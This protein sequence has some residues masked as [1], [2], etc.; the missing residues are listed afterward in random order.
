MNIE[1][2]IAA[3][4][5]DLRLLTELVNNT[6]A[7]NQKVLDKAKKYVFVETTYLY[8]DC[9][10]DRYLHFPDARTNIDTPNII[11]CMAFHNGE[12]TFFVSRED[13]KQ[14]YTKYNCEEL[15]PKFVLQEVYEDMN[16]L[17]A[18]KSITD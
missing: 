7:T 17:F 4:R 5:E 8:G 2:E 11:G 15:C 12:A 10:L 3:M 18:T 13:A 9:R 14:T 16:G 6:L 1:K